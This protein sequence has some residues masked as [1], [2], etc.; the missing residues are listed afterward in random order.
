VF[1]VLISPVSLDLRIGDHVS[2]DWMMTISVD[3]YVGSADFICIAGPTASQDQLIS[4][5]PSWLISS[6]SQDLLH[7]RTY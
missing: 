2:D 1:T 6:A 3:H 4:S 7:R 5:L